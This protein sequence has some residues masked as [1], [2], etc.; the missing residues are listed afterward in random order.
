MT[1]SLPGR[2]FSLRGLL[3]VIVGVAGGY[4]YPYGKVPSRFSDSKETNVSPP[5]QSPSKAITPS[6][7]SPPAVLPALP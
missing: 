7:K 5:S 2:R 4:P 6:A 3:S 1:G